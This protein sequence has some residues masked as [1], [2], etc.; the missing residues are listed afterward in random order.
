MSCILRIFDDAYPEENKGTEALPVMPNKDEHICSGIF[1]PLLA[2]EKCKHLY[3]LIFVDVDTLYS[4]DS[5]HRMA[6]P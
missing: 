4:L 1:D 2:A 3:L 5:V 6:K